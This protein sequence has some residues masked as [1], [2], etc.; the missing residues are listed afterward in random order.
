MIAKKVMPIILEN[1][2][3]KY[4]LKGEGQATSRHFLEW[5]LVRA[6][7]IARGR[8]RSKNGAKNKNLHLR[9]DSKVIQLSEYRS[10]YVFH[11]F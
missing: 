1:S 8:S 7:N 10:R 6:Q 5:F 2:L 11:I 3:L 9:A 4:E